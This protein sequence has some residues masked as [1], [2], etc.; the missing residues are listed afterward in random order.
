MMGF[1]GIALAFFFF[2]EGRVSWKR[3]EYE[4]D[5]ECTDTV[6]PT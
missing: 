5:V 3:E 1:M 4:M 2:F 6:R